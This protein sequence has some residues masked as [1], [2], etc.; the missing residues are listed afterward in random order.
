VKLGYK[1]PQE[2]LELQ[3]QLLQELQA[4]QV[5]QDHREFKVIQALQG[6]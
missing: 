2:I 3:V 1:D 5:L 4:T 6:L